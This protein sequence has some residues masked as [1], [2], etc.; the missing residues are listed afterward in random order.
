MRGW[1]R[2]PGHW[3]VITSMLVA[4]IAIPVAGETAGASTAGSHPQIGVVH[5]VGAAAQEAAG[6]FWTPTRMA[7]AD[8]APV[9]TEA[10]AGRAVSPPPGIP[11]ARLFNGV[12]TVGALF[13]TNGTAKHFCTASVVD[14]ARA[15]LILTAAHCV[16]TSKYSGNIE[17]VPGY[18]NGRRPHGAW[19]VKT[20]LVASGWARSHNID[21]DFAFLAV[22]PPAGTQRPIQQVTGGLQ[23]GVNRPYR[24][25][26]EA[27]GYNNA[28]SRPVA[29]ATHSFEFEADQ[30]EFYCHDFRDGTSGGPWIVRFNRR[31]GTGVVIGVIGGFEQGGDVEWAS[32]SAY[33]GPSALDLF[34]QAERQ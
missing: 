5:T 23:L 4:V 32:Y 22:V 27:V 9:P 24:R 10:R 2:L 21:L 8:P 7:A 33:F 25:P 19:V 29:C 28:N 15:N 31:N 12:P 1:G 26:I 17:F 30:M 16:Y 14:S 18:H 34:L 3:V 13:Y 20:I 11:T 6:A